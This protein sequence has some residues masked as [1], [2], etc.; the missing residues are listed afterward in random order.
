M[1]A[2]SDK[3]E[4]QHARAD[5]ATRQ[6]AVIDLTAM[7]DQYRQLI[8]T[9]GYRPEHQLQLWRRRATALQYAITAL[10]TKDHG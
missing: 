1:T 4:R 3:L 7:R 10:E 6:A 2:A 8:D 5:N 9:G